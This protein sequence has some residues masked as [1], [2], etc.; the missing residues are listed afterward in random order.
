[1]SGSLAGQRLYYYIPLTIT[2]GAMRD[3]FRIRKSCFMD[4]LAEGNKSMPCS[5]IS[6]M[7]TAFFFPSFF[8][9]ICNPHV[10]GNIDNTIPLF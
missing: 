1:M 5:N 6:L 3:P 7:T 10:I 8:I 2:A 9:L 4:T